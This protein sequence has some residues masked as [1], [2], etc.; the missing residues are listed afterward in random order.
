VH[1]EPRFSVNGESF[2][3]QHQVQVINVP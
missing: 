2:K 1:V 3:Y